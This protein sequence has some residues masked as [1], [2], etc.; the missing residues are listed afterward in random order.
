MKKKK[1][2]VTLIL[3]DN[4]PEIRKKIED[5]GISVCCCASFDGAIWIDTSL[6]MRFC[7][8]VHGI[9]YKDDD[10]IELPWDTGNTPEEVCGYYLEYVMHEGEVIFAKDVD[11]FIAKFKETWK[12]VK[13]TSE[14]DKESDC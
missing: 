4:S 1:K 3:K 13:I 2:S 11:D 6:S 8:D 14:N 9:G 10:D 5:A 7:Y 12:D